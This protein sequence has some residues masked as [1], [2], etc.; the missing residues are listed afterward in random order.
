MKRSL[1]HAISSLLVLTLI[2]AISPAHALAL[3][4]N[5]LD[6][7]NTSTQISYV[8][9]RETTNLTALEIKRN[10]VYA[11]QLNE[12][13]GNSNVFE[14]VIEASEITGNIFLQLLI[15]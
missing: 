13:I 5:M 6:S 2:I 14:K 3:E 7:L 10:S 9:N 12:A 8:N 4:Q 1:L 11:L 15:A